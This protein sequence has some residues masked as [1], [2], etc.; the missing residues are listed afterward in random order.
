MIGAPS[1]NSSRTRKA[2]S[3]SARPALLRLLQRLVLAVVAIV[4][5]ASIT[6]VVRRAA[7]AGRVD[8]AVRA[9]HRRAASAPEST[10]EWRADDVRGFV[11]LQALEE[12]DLD[13]EDAPFAFADDPADHADRTPLPRRP[14]WSG[15]GEASNDTSRFAAGTGLPRGPPV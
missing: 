11:D 8:T 7:V 5:C 3:K 4:V 9:Q 1:A 6:S 14:A 13:E 15:R 12:D 10:Q 2:L